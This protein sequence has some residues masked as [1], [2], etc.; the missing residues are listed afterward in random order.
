MMAPGPL[1]GYTISKLNINKS[2]LISTHDKH[3]SPW[4]WAKAQ[5]IQNIEAVTLTMELKVCGFS[6]LM[7]SKGKTIY[8]YMSLLRTYFPKGT[9]AF[10][11]QFMAVRTYGFAPKCTSLYFKI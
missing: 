7:I 8:S 6:L 11:P 5:N 2:T 3:R 9:P 1:G 4:C 10:P